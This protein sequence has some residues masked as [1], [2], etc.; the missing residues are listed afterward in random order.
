MQSLQGQQEGR[1]FLLLDGG[2]MKHNDNYSRAVE[3]LGS[4]ERAISKLY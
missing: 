4:D 3:R 2:L 1:D